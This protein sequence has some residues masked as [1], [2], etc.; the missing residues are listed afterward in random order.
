M[1]TTKETIEKKKL[2]AMIKEMKD[3]SKQCDVIATKGQ[4]F[5]ERGKE[6]KNIDVSLARSD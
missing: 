1:A 2:I 3:I 5:L 6:L 4:E